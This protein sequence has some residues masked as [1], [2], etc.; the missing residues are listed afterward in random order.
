MSRFPRQAV[1]AALLSLLPFPTASFAFTGDALA[2]SRA[3][4]VQAPAIIKGRVTDSATGRPIAGAQVV[5]LGGGTQ[6]VQGATTSN[7]G[8]YTLRGVAPGTVT[9]RAL[10][11]G[12]QP[13]DQAVVVTAQGEVTANFSLASAVTRLEQVVTT[14]TGEQSRRQ[15]GM[16]V[17]TV[18]A[19]SI[20]GAAPVANVQ[21]VLTARTAGVL[22]TQTL[23]QVGNAPTVRLRGVTSVSLGSAPLIVVD[24]VRVGAGGGGG[25]DTINPEE[26]ESIDVIKG[27]S[28]SALY[29]T[30]AANGVLVIKTKR[31]RAGRTRWAGFT[32]HGQTE[33]PGG[34]FDNYWNF[35]KNIVNG[36]PV[37]SA[38]P[39]HCLVASYAAGR[40]TIDSVTHINPYT[41]PQTNPFMNGPVHNYGIQASG[42]TEAL[43]FF[44]SAD[45]VDETGPHYMN[46]FEQNRL[47]EATGKAPDPDFIR[48]NTNRQNSVR[49]NFAFALMPNANLDVSVGYHHK[50]VRQPVDGGF[51]GGFTNQYQA[52]P[53]CVG[54]STQCS[55]TN[56]T[57]KIYLGDVFSMDGRTKLQRLTGSSSLNWAP[58]SW[59]QLTAEGG[60]DNGNS[61]DTRLQLLGQGPQAVSFGPTQLQN[62]SGLDLTRANSLQYTTTLRAAA[63][64]QLTSSIHTVTTLGGQWFK[65]GTYST[66]G[67]GYGLGVGSVTPNTAATRTVSTATVENA[68][69]GVY[70]Q[71][72]L[73]WRDVLFFTAAARNDHNSAFGRSSGNTVYPSANVSYVIS[74]ESWF[75]QLPGVNR[76][77]L[78][79]SMGTAGLAPGATAALQFLTARTYP[80]GAQDVSGLTIGSIGNASLKPEVTTEIEGGLDIG[81]VRDRVNIE[82]TAYSKVSKDQIFLRT[83]APSLGAGT[84]QTINIAKVRNTGL[85]LSV[86]GQ[87]L[88]TRRFT[89]N[90]RLTGSRIGNKL[91]TIGGIPLGTGRGQRNAAGYPL[92]AI[93]DRA[94]KYSDLNGDGF[95]TVNELTAVPTT[96]PGANSDSMI[97]PSTPR[98][99]AGLSNTFGILNNHVRLNTLL[100]YRGKYWGTNGVSTN[101]CTANV[102]CVTVN[103]PNNSSLELQAATV[104]S[105][106]TTGSA[107]NASRWLWYSRNDFIKLREISISADLPARFVNRLLRGER[108]TLIL[109]GRNLATL[110]TMWPGVDPEENG[111]GNPPVLRLWYARLNF[112]F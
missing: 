53:G 6:R 86:D 61:Y 51:F 108:A 30:A 52:A 90:A 82:A 35:G 78:R 83:L 91:I 63:T 48:P 16:T 97:G 80:Q 72:Q 74:E 44:I 21:Q 1:L 36:A 95:I 98:F 24:N 49:G 69:Y 46:E 104:A 59:L 93:W 45:M 109:S 110:W 92:S 105:Q 47:K 106:T 50:E 38:T 88:D 56:G 111:A 85:E 32:Q 55:A 23:G 76:L 65:N 84:N 89:W 68:T 27:P 13:S 102:N 67:Q 60:I 103:D 64:R 58:K 25:L 4:L 112:A 87:V 29:G 8:E 43:R 9:M 37:V 96:I 39:V 42:G 62:F 73:A 17:G 57:A 81:L 70:L 101:R 15:V 14:A 77:R 40:C 71:S 12:Y 2:A 94:V 11:L 79:S 10:R 19:D 107:I 20:V 34:F 31:G 22:V 54:G 75:P 100:D 7:S 66:I 41:N 3:D 5:V 28:A 99:E 18:T 33:M 26:I